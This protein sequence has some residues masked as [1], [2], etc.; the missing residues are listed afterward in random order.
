MQENQKQSIG[1]DKMKK[2]LVLGVA[3]ILWGQ[4]LYEEHFT[5]G[6]AQLT[7]S[8]FFTGEDTIVVMQDTTTPEG[9]GWIGVLYGA[10]FGLAYAGDLSLDDISIE[11]W[12]YV[13]VTPGGDGPYNGIAVRVNPVVGDFY[14][15]SA[16][17]DTDR[18][19]RLTYHNAANNFMPE[20]IHVWEE[21]SVPGGLPQE[22]GWHRMKLKII[23]D[24]LWA[25]FDGQELPGCPYIHSTGS[26]Y[27]FFGI[28]STSMAGDAETRVDSIVVLAEPAG[29][30]EQ[31]SQKMDFRIY[32]LNPRKVLFIYRGDETP[33]DIKI[34]NVSGSF[35]ERVILKK[36]GDAYRGIWNGKD[37]LGRD[38]RRGIYLYRVDKSGRRGKLILY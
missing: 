10:P 6:S 32:H 37:A 17:L 21:G 19:L 3:S 38:V 18:R 29:V 27:G 26:G 33:G 13:I 8:G 28:Y 15:F 4:V 25:Y 34:Y 23:A 20:Y 5:G 14:I 7:W 11:A 22:S 12:V 9:D 31:S 30:K 2:V 24:S 1:G 16:D 35:V 36:V